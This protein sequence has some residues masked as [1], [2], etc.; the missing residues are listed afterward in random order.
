MRLK[1]QSAGF[2]R[3]AGSSSLAIGVQ[4]ASFNAMMPDGLGLSNT[5]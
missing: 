4:L 1:D 3:F 2:R 5:G